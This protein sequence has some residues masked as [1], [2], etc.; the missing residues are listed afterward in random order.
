MNAHVKYLLIGG[1]LASISAAEA[2]RQRD[3]QGELL[4]IGQEIN[5]PYHRPPLSKEYL[6][7]QKGHEELFTHPV[8]WYREQAI[9]LRTGRRGARLDTARRAVTLDDAEEI[10]FDLLLLATGASPKHLDIPGADL[11]NLFYLRTLEDA[12]RLHH[13][14][15]Q[16]ERLR[17][18]KPRVAVIGG[19]LLGVELAASF[20]QLE[21][22]VDLIVAG[23][24]PWS[25]FAGEATGNFVTHA[26]EARGVTVHTGPRPARLEGDG[27]VQR[28]VLGDDRAI[29]CD[30][31]VA[32][33]GVQPNKEILRG[34]PIAAETAILDDAHA[35]TNVPGIFAAGDCCA[36]FDPLFAKHR[37]LDHWDSAIVTGRLAGA[38]MT[39]AGQTYECASSFFSDVFDWSL[40]AWGESRLVDRRLVRGTPNVE[41]P[42]FI[43]FGLSSDG[44]VTQVLAVN[45]TGEDDVLAEMVRR[46]LLVDGVEET[47]KE[48]SSDLK[49]L[50]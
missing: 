49:A 34:T 33:V 41:R 3:R 38:N 6:R 5:R 25:K 37:I 28:V 7:R 8:S 47:L 14:M 9:E 26:L 45:H 12:E 13:A 21:L 24:H 17:R 19:G 10:T 1:G 36:I 23:A 39:G 30:F 48:P 50:L 20:R 31:A 15:D 4:I 40:N 29:A 2:I 35:R 44:R 32:A 11:P 18:A 27:R 42:D 22:N 43:E 46:R 16:L